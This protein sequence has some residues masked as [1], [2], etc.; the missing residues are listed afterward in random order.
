M[1]KTIRIFS[2]IS[3]NFKLCKTASKEQLINEQRDFLFLKIFEYFPPLSQ[4]KKINHLFLLI[5]QLK[6]LKPV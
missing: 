6:V 3:K 5:K 1:G 4:N 2:A